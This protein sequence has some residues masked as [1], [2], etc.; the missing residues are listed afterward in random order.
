MCILYPGRIGIL[1]FGFCVRRKTGEPGEKLLEQGE[2]PQQIQ[3]TYETGRNSCPLLRSCFIGF[4]ML[5]PQNVFHAVSTLQST[6]FIHFL[7]DQ[8]S[9]RSYVG[10]VYA[11]AVPCS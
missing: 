2:N 9:C 8:V 4:V 1:S 5:V 6:V 7:A 3:T 11:Y 10:S